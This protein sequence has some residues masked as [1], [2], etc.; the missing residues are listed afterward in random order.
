MKSEIRENFE[1]KIRKIASE[2]K[3]KETE[4]ATARPNSLVPCPAVWLSIR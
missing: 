2:R 3:D 4:T 1:I